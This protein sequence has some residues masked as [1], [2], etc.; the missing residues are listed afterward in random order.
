MY[1]YTSVSHV[2]EVVVVEI[3]SE[4]LVTA[5]IL[6]DLSEPAPKQVTGSLSHGSAFCQSSKDLPGAMGHMGPGFKLDQWKKPKCCNCLRR[7]F[8]NFGARRAANTLSLLDNLGEFPKAFSLYFLM[9]DRGLA[10]CS[11]VEPHS[12]RQTG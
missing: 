5:P 7:T 12:K 6:G 4:E 10:E 9:Q 1:M 8:R 2:F 3:N 11:Q